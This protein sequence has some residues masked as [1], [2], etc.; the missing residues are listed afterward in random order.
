[1]NALATPKPSLQNRLEGIALTAIFQGVPTFAAV[2][3]MAKLAHH[4]IAGGPVSFVAAASLLHALMTPWLA[5]KFPRFF[6]NSYEPLFFDAR[7]CF[8]EKLS[9]WRA[10]PIV[11]LQLVTNVM[12]LSVL[13]VAVAS[14]G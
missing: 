2:T 7:L 5:P 8:V 10:Q 3:L 4:Q 12:M 14:M 1:M 6:R 11:S 13:A 9:Q